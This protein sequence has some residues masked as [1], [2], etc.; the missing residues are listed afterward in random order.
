LALSFIL[1]LSLIF[2][3]IIKKINLFYEN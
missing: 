3:L 2:F 1:V